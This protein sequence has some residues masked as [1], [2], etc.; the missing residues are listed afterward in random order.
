M[1]Y[2]PAM[3]A[4]V[5]EWATGDIDISSV[6][7]I[8]QAAKILEIVMA[9]GL[10]CLS[11]FQAD[12]ISEVAHVGKDDACH[13]KFTDVPQTV[14]H[15]INDIYVH[16]SQFFIAHLP[17]NDVV[18]YKVTNEAIDE[19][20]RCRKNDEASAR[21]DPDLVK[22]SSSN[23]KPKI[24]MIKDNIILIVINKRIVIWNMQELSQEI[25]C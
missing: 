25:G 22:L 7:S 16:I 8:P 9:N 24:W 2:I 23:V 18:A 14:Q 19:R 10:W 15:L 4:T 1:K 6:K 17:Q 3:V 5:R 11:V 13:R 21:V 12:Q 20:N